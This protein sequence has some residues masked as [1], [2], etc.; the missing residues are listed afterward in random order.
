MDKASRML[1]STVL[2]MYVNGYG[3]TYRQLTP[4]N[5]RFKKNDLMPEAIVNAAHHGVAMVLQMTGI[6]VHLHQEVTAHEATVNALPV[7]VPHLMTIMIEATDDAVHLGDTMDHHHRGDTTL[8]PMIIEDHLPLH[9]DTA[10]PMLAMEIHTLVLEAR[11]AME[12]TAPEVVAA[13]ILRMKIVLDIRTYSG[14]YDFQMAVYSFK[15]WGC[16]M[17]FC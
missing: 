5:L 14:D 7:V 6:V 4:C 16:D 10:I 8:I 1:L 17:E 13:A 9:E 15:S 11:L 3:H 12:A 2:Q